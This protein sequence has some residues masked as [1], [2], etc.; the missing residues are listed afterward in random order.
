MLFI[1]DDGSDENENAQDSKDDSEKKKKT[2]PKKEISL[3][4]FIVNYFPILILNEK[5]MIKFCSYNFF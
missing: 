2:K 4:K 5:K 1:L 3:G